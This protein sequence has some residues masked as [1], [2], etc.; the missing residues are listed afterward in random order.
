M[1]V[2]TRSTTSSLPPLCSSC[3]PGPS[4]PRTPRTSCQ[5]GHVLPHLRCR[6]CVLHAGRVRHALRRVRPRQER[7][8]H[9]ASLDTFYHIFAAALVFFMQAGSVR[10]KNAKNIMPV[11]T[12]ST[13]SS[14]PPLCSSCRP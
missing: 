6:P 2:W 3:R 12:R 5:F 13:T 4:A 7:Q 8:E 10:A 9:H 14:L 11:W 1:P